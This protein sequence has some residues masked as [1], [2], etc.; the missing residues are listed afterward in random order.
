MFRKARFARAL[1]GGPGERSSG[2]PPRYK[3]KVAVANDIVKP[4]NSMKKAALFAVVAIAWMAFDRITKAYFEGAYVLGQAGANCGLF[5]FTLV[6]NTGA[7]WGMF[8]DSTFMLGVTSCVVCALIAVAF[9]LWDKL[10]GHA[11]SALETCALALVFAGGLGNAFD[12]FAQNYVIDFID[13]TFIDFPVFNIADIG[14]TCGFVL[15]VVG[16]LLATRKGG[17]HV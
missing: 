7:A 14:V 8:G 15:V 10:A 11:P 12:R 16:Y 2:P 6:H 4:K 17:A 3:G 5:R 1:F 9:A 13:F